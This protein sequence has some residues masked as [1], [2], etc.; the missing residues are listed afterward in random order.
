[1]EAIPRDTWDMTLPFLRTGYP[2]ISQRCN[3][4]GT[5]AFLTRMMLQKTL[6]MRGE[7]GAKVFYVP[8]RVTRKGAL[9]ITV[10]KLLQ[11]KGSVAT[12]RNRI[13]LT[14]NASGTGR[15]RPST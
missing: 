7:E 9:P 15:L 14:R 13:V 4:L 11:D 3:E 6:C 2:F 8:D 10:L 1:M 5:D 12:G